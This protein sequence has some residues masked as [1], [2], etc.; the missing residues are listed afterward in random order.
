MSEFDDN[1]E[2]DE[3][4]DGSNL[5]RD[6]RRQ[7]RDAK[8]EAKGYAEMATANAEAAKRIAFLDAEIPDTAQT[9]FFREKYDGEMTS[10]AIR[11]SA[12]QYGFVVDEDHSQELGDLVRQSEASSGAEGPT[13]LG[14]QE[15]MN[16]EMD[17]A[18]RDAPRGQESK[19]IAEVVAR[20]TRSP[21]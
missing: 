8:N 2:N 19:A 4:D 21:V 10:E 7:L 1:E 18:A 20:Y 16:A 6:L 13:V 11:S 15:E 14:S 17:K 5:V 9:R 3:V 12:Q